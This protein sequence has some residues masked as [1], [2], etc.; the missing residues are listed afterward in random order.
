MTKA[1]RKTGKPQALEE[2]DKELQAQEPTLEQFV[3][4]MHGTADTPQTD[5]PS[6]EWLKDQFQTKSAAVRYLIN[7]GKEVKDIC[8]H[9][10]MKYQHVRNVAN[11]P[12]KRGPNEDW[13]K[14]LLVDSDIPNANEFKP[15]P[16]PKP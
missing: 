10:G 5:M 9:L 14:P 8:K 6:L 2:D 16:I 15:K 4:E 3:A 12:L 7:Q 1:P 13:R 11:T